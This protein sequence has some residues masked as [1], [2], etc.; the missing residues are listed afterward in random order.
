MGG[1]EDERGGVS[2]LF[3]VLLDNMSVIDICWIKRFIL[4]VVEMLF[5][6]CKWERIVS[7]ILRFNVLIR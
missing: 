7:I 6:E 3:E 1:V 4:C 5:Y 2:L